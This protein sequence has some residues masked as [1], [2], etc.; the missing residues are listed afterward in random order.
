MTQAM[1]KIPV[2]YPK[3]IVGR[4]MYGGQSTHVPVRI[5]L[6]GVM[7]IIFAQSLIVFP[8]TFAAFIKNPVAVWLQQ[9]AVA[10]QPGSTTSSTRS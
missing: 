6:A 9:D 10:R 4:Q 7:P 2:Q 1:R 5:N 3:R 8:G